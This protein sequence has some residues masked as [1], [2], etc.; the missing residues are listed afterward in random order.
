MR[1]YFRLCRNS[2]QLA[3][4]AVMAGLLWSVSAGGKAQSPEQKKATVAWL[5]SLQ[6]SGGGFAP[7]AK[8]TEATL[9]ATL[10]AIRALKYFGGELK[11]RQA[12]EKF[13]HHCYDNDKGA[14]AATQGDK[15]D[16][17]STSLG[18]M[19]IAELK[20]PLEKYL[21]RPVTFLCVNAK[22][23]E[24]IRIAA[25][26][27]EAVN[28]KCTLADDWLDSVQRMQNPDGTFGKDDPRARTTAAAVVTIL[29]L[30]GKVFKQDEV[31][32]TLKAAQRP[33]GGWGKDAAESDLDAT[34][35]VMRAFVMLKARPDTAACRT[36]IAKCRNADG[37]Y[38]PQP[39][40]PGT[41]SATYYAGIVLYWLEQMK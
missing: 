35:L 8:A 4:F 24:E 23:F 17:R 33:D 22:S 19:A 30:G 13:V 39:G 2:V 28:T 5:Q 31:L 37:S 26:A 3:V 14:F 25:A 7:D 16:V 9:P 41:A 38:G 29:R 15:S 11:N 18:L 36:F 40:Q 1:T 10:A 20:L 12:C 6:K 27:Y 21:V 34:Y 32:K